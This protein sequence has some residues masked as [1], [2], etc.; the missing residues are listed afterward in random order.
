M[1]LSWSCPFQSGLDLSP[2]CLQ[3]SKN[4][5]MLH[6]SI[7]YTIMHSWQ[8]Y[9]FGS[10]CMIWNGLSIEYGI[11]FDGESISG[12]WFGWNWTEKIIIILTYND[13]ALVWPMTRIF[14]TGR[15]PLR[16]LTLI[17]PC[18]TSVLYWGFNPRPSRD[19]GGPLPTKTHLT[20]ILRTNPIGHNHHSH[21]R[22]VGKCLPHTCC[23]S[24]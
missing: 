6:H 14:F 15:F 13:T 16:S 12:L 3:E 9:K 5:P 17:N 21:V 1:R 4:Y 10:Q 11:I 7:N 22:V 24:V 19:L 18:A 2:S 23:Y 20:S 8:W